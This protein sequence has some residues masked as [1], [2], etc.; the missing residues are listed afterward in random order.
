MVSESSSSIEH[1]ACSTLRGG[2][3]HRREFTV[4]LVLGEYTL[5]H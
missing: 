1:G 4:P 5:K 2:I 3:V